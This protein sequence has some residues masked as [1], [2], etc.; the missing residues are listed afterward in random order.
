[1]RKIRFNNRTIHFLQMVSSAGQRARDPR[2][3]LELGRVRPLRDA[4][5]V[6]GLEHLD[7]GPHRWRREVEGG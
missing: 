6:D 1:M 5:E 3:Q 4:V 7:D 2:S